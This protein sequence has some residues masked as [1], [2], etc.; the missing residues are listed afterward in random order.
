MS[1]LR[2]ALQIGV[3]L[4]IDSWQEFDRVVTLLQTPLL[5]SSSSV[6]GI[7]VNPLLGEGKVASMSVSGAR[8]KFGLALTSHNHDRI[9]REFQ[10]HHW[11]GQL[12]A[13]AVMIF[14][15]LLVS[16][17]LKARAPQ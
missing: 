14:P 15:F 9:V 7:R 11:Q 1:D 8:S 4:N 3:H 17:H 5:Q 12:L 16:P 10:S 13:N 6:I 2:V